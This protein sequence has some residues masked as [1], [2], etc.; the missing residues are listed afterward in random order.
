[1]F[2]LIGESILGDQGWTPKQISKYGLVYLAAC[3][4]ALLVAV[5]YWNSLGLFN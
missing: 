5:P 1:M 2:A 3:I 4:I